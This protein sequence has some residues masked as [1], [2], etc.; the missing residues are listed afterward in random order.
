MT[1]AVLALEKEVSARFFLTFFAHFFHAVVTE[2][3]TSA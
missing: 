2:P 3:H 1:L